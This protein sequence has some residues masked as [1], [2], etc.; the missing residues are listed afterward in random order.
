MAKQSPVKKKILAKARALFGRKGYS[1]T[2]IKDIAV[3]YGCEPANIYNFFQGKEEMLFE[4]LKEETQY[5][6]SHLGYLK[7]DAKTSPVEQLKYIIKVQSE[8]ALG[9]MKTGKLLFDSELRKLTKAHQ[10]EII[11]LRDE[12]DVILRLVIKRGMDAGIFKVTDLKITAFSL[13]SA[14]MRLRVWYNSKGPLS[15]EE[16]IR[17]MCDISLRTLGYI[18]Q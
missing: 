10:K 15:R 9:E 17:R 13:V 12:Y 14:V 3:A 5:L 1:E 18:E 2:T 6:V 8:L 11:K 7:Q 16:I 4:I